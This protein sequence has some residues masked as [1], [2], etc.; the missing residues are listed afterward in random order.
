MITLPRGGRAIPVTTASGG[1][2]VIGDNAAAYYQMASRRRFA[3][4]TFAW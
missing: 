2:S 1:L 3:N 4:R